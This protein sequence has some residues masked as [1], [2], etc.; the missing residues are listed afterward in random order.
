MVNLKY[1]EPR[2]PREA[3]FSM[4]YAMATMLRYGTVTLADFTP[5][6]VLDDVTR[7]LMPRVEMRLDSARA[8]TA[9]Q[10]LPHTCAVTL[11]DGR[12]LERVVHHA[13]GSMQNPFSA[14]ERQVKFD[15]CTS[16]ILPEA[17]LAPLRESL[18]RPQGVKVRQLLA[19]LQF[20]AQVDDGTRFG[21]P[22]RATRQR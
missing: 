7:R 9:T 1:P 19:L 5:Q 17:R 13:K 8:E 10:L 15:Q 4:P 11:K 2:D 6:A 18:A 16:G 14:L 21:R 3:M 20:E 12:R 22:P